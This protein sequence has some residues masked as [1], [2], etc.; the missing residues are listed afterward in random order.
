[1]STKIVGP[2]GVA[3]PCHVFSDMS[4]PAAVLALSVSYHEYGLWLC[5]WRPSLIVDL[6]VTFALE[7]GLSMTPIRGSQSLFMFAECGSNV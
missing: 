1:M 2:Y 3:H 4:V 5:E 6:R 7:I